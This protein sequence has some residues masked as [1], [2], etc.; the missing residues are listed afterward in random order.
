MCHPARRYS[1]DRWASCIATLLFDPDVKLDGEG[2]W[3]SSD[4]LRA[5]KTGMSLAVRYCEARGCDEVIPQ[6]ASKRTRFHSAA[7]R[8]R[9]SRARSVLSPRDESDTLSA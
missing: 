4:R 2:R 3:L 1:K 8:S 7:C 6:D 5:R 9:A